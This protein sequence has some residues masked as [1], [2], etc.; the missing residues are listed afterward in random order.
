MADETTRSPTSA[1]AYVLHR[2][3]N[4]AADSLPV[5]D[6]LRG[7]N[8]RSYSHAHVQVVPS[9]GANPPARV[10]FWSEEAGKFINAH[11][12]LTW[13]AGGINTPYEFTVECRGREMIVV[14]ESGIAATQ[15]V[16]VFVAGYYVER[17]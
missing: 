13:A 5:T 2:K 4:D 15:Q 9:G 12:A 16:K 10:M 7:I 11:T 8:M 14:C 3:I 6:R 17:V 1:P